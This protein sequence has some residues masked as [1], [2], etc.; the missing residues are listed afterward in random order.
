MRTSCLLALLALMLAPAR[1]LANQPQSQSV[2][3]MPG[4]SVV[5]QVPMVIREQGWTREIIKT[6]G[7]TTGLTLAHPWVDGSLMLFENG[8]LWTPGEQ[9][10]GLSQTRQVTFARPEDPGAVFNAFYQYRQ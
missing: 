10:Q 3:D 5:I 9:Y 4:A 8:V 1:P 2:K 7:V 6:S